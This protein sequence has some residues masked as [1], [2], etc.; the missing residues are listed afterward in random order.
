M[1]RVRILRSGEKGQL[2]PSIQDE[3]EPEPVTLPSPLM[4]AQVSGP[5]PQ[6]ARHVAT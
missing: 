5:A 2:R 3:C 1:N 4:A 6:E